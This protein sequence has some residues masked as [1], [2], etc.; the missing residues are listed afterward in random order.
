M[1][2]QYLPQCVH[3]VRHSV[4]LLLVSGQEAAKISET[5]LG[6]C[7]SSPLSVLLPRLPLEFYIDV[8]PQDPLVSADVG[9][10]PPCNLV[11]LGQRLVLKHFLHGMRHSSRPAKNVFE[12]LEI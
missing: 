10:K 5:S 12:L 6:E 1:L 3:P 9:G 11:R 7:E 2:S 4:P 8:V